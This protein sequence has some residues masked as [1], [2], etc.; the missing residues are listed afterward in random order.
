M[1]SNDL[2]TKVKNA[3][4][5]GHTEEEIAA[6]IKRYRELNPE[7]VD[8]TPAIPPAPY[9]GDTARRVAES[10]PDT[11][12]GGVANSFK[13]GEALKAGF[14]GARGW[15]RGAIL[16][17]P[18]SLNDA[19]N[20]IAAGLDSLATNPEAHFKAMGP[21]FREMGHEFANTVSH[22]GSNP[23]AFGRMMGQLTGQPIVMEGALAGTGA[24]AR[25]APVQNFAKAHALQ[26]AKVLEPVGRA[27]EGSRAATSGVPYTK[28]GAIAK[29]AG[30]TVAPVGR[31]IRQTGENLRMFGNSVETPRNLAARTANRP[32]G[33][34]VASGDIF[35]DV[36]V[37]DNQPP[38]VESPD[39][40]AARGS[41]D[42]PLVY[43]DPYGSPRSVAENQPPILESP[44]DLAARGG[45]TNPAFPFEVADP[46]DIDPIFRKPGPPPSGAAPAL[47]KDANSLTPEE[48]M[49]AAIQ[50]VRDRFVKEADPTTQAPPPPYSHG[51]AAPPEQPRF[52]VR[53]PRPTKDSPLSH[54]SLDELIKIQEDAAAGRKP[55]IR[56]KAPKT[57]AAAKN[58]PT[59]EKFEPTVDPKEVLKGV[60]PNDLKAALERMKARDAGVDPAT[61][62]ILTP[63][64]KPAKVKWR[65]PFE[66]FKNET[67]AVGR[68]IS[69]IIERQAAEKMA[70]QS[71]PRPTE[72]MPDWGMETIR[73]PRPVNPLRPKVPP[74]QVTNRQMFER[75]GRIA[76][77]NRTNPGQRFADEVLGGHEF[78]EDMLLTPDEL[79][80][81]DVPVSNSPFENQFDPR[82]AP[83]GVVSEATPA[84]E[85]VFR[86]GGLKGRDGHSFFTTDKNEAMGYASLAE[87][88]EDRL[89][90]EGTL[91]KG[92]Y[93]A[94]NL[95]TKGNIPEAWADIQRAVPNDVVESVFQRSGDPTQV[96]QQVMRGEP[97][98][99]EWVKFRDSFDKPAE[100]KPEDWGD[101]GGAEKDLPTLVNDKS[102]STVAKPKSSFSDRVRRLLKDEAGEL[103]DDVQPRQTPKFGRGG[104]ADFDNGP[105][106]IVAPMG[107]E[108][109]SAMDFIRRY[110]NNDLSTVEQVN[111]LPEDIKRGFVKLWKESQAKLKRE[112]A[113]VVRPSAFSR[114]LLKDERGMVG[115]D[116]NNPSNP[117]PNPR[118]KAIEVLRA[119]EKNL[120]RSLTPKEIVE[121]Q[122]TAN[123]TRAAGSN[124][125]KSPSVGDRNWDVM[126]P[127]GKP[128]GNIAVTR[129][130][131][132]AARKAGQIPEGMDD[133]DVSNAMFQQKLEELA[134]E[135]GYTPND[136]NRLKINYNTK[137]TKE[138]PA[139][140]VTR[141]STPTP[142][143]KKY[144]ITGREVKS[145]DAPKLVDPKTEKLT[146]DPDRAFEP[147]GDIQPVAKEA[148]RLETANAPDES[149]K[150]LLPREM[151]YSLGEGETFKDRLTQLINA[152]TDVDL[153]PV[154][155][156]Q[157]RAEIAAEEAGKAK[158]AAE[159]QQMS[160]INKFLQS[161]H[162]T[163]PDSTTPLLDLK[164][165][166]LGSLSRGKLNQNAREWVSPRLVRQNPTIARKYKDVVRKKQN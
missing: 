103:G 102:G 106:E 68:D 23:H 117:K 91:P 58:P 61:G 122:D 147:G 49:A 21:A 96:P 145:E 112:P 82:I 152:V 12:W 51:A 76:A 97:G 159:A 154:D 72:N 146:F 133:V 160:E 77:E 70:R 107:I 98:Y 148:S 57:K 129:A 19:G 2:R 41:G 79:R 93:P 155:M 166:D 136:L 78:A 63:P 127:S 55:Q 37:A 137:A 123:A 47:V 165:I 25:T 104:V 31:A 20:A 124:P 161:I 35:S 38:I 139:K 140:S 69:D 128:I 65:N 14:E 16:D 8:R 162:E 52:S 42:P 118:E 144:D 43:P 36:A 44:N 6:M 115:K 131:I 120:G 59:A 149:F 163:L 114:N 87:R 28:T 156:R 62:E 88:P 86:G 27:M 53:T 30:R 83:G 105:P 141:E 17:I 143:V 50:E 67:G 24:L 101:W 132:A 22:A 54:L 111:Q 119:I 157:V 110:T 29:V 80:N 113:E 135:N 99:D 13:T 39:A 45:G 109:E 100:I 85:T 89:L 81:P 1:P 48:Q 40:F 7:P 18:S 138:A 64:T 3:I 73:E 90:W 71:A 10:E 94:G 4:D 84:R 121:L 164:K 33:T 56:A 46:V 9:T 26:A 150:R 15:L 66:R 92:E 153:N 95:T 134:A 142:K 5:A 158:A 11:F 108:G 32:P 75:S 125:K 116:I 151:Q 34:T 130:E 74:G 126:H 60:D